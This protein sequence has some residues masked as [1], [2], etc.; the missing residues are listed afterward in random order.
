MV[1]TKSVRSAARLCADSRN[2]IEQSSVLIL[3]SGSACA[4]HR[5][6]IEKSRETVAKSRKQISQLRLNCRLLHDLSTR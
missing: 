1:D 3:D 5:D 2:L 4:A 6:Q